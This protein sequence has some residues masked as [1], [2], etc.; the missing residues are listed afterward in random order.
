MRLRS[1]KIR[2]DRRCKQNITDAECV[3]EEDSG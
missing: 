1:F 3:D 2:D